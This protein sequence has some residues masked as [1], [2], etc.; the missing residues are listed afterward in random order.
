MC[1]IKSNWHKP[2]P[3]GGYFCSAY[4]KMKLV[5]QTVF[6]PSQIHDSTD[7]YSQIPTIAVLLFTLRNDYTWWTAEK[8]VQRRSAHPGRYDISLPTRTKSTTDNTVLVWREAK[9]K[10]SRV[11]SNF[12]LLIIGHVTALRLLLPKG[13]ESMTATDEKRAG[14]ETVLSHLETNTQTD[15]P[16]PDSFP[17][18]EPYIPRCPTGSLGCRSRGILLSLLLLCQQSTQLTEAVHDQCSL[19]L[20]EPPYARRQRL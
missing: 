20:L 4:K 8:R 9:R 16:N 15:T 14:V 3:W 13:R 5:L 18:G 12:I 2:N 1:T 7:Y 11:I 10:N 19:L 17:A 6:H